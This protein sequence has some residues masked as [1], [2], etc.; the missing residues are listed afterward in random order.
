MKPVLRVVNH[1]DGFKTLSKKTNILQTL[2]NYYTN[3][4]DLDKVE[5]VLEPNSQNYQT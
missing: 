4:K 3:L 1:I 5:A 2:K